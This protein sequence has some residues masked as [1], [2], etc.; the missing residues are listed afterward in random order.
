MRRWEI[1][2]EWKQYILAYRIENEEEGWVF[3]QFI[4]E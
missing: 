4:E 2:K 3:E 1:M